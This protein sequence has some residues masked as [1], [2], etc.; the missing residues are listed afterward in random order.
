MVTFGPAKSRR[1]LLQRG[2]PFEL[3][4][5]MEWSTAL[6]TGDFRRAYPEPRWVAVGRIRSELHTV[7]FCFEPSGIRVI[8]LRRS[9]RKEKRA[10]HAS[11]TPT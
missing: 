9:N 5:E 10:W 1:N 2:L 4:E 3:V 6:I 7:V 11:R 8:S